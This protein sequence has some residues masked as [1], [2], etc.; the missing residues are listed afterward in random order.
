MPFVEVR[1]GD[2]KHRPI[3]YLMTFEEWCARNNFS[4]VTGWRIMKSGTGPKITR[5]TA[6]RIGIREDHHAEWLDS[7]EVRTT[8]KPYRS[9]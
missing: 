1:A 7:R 9:K 6:R 5:I 2:A 4:R 8:T 3:N